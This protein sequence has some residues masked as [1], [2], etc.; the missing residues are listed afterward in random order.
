ML[1][2]PTRCPQVLPEAVI[3]AALPNLC[4]CAALCEDALASLSAGSGNSDH[5]ARPDALEHC[6]G[7]Q[8]SGRYR[9]CTRSISVIR[10]DHC[11]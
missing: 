5:G 4:A 1:A 6:L 9:C 3:P 11:S 7:K 2:E 10:P 8:I